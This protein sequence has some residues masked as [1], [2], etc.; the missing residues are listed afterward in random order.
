MIKAQ[1]IAI[2]V[3]SGIKGLKLELFGISG[4]AAQ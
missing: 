1:A 4:A 3:P 2:Y